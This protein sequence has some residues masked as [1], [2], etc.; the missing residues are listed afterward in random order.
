MKETHAM[1]RLWQSVIMTGIG[2]TLM[3]L[4]LISYFFMLKGFEEHSIRFGV[5]DTLFASSQAEACH[6]SMIKQM[7]L[8]NPYECCQH[9]RTTVCVWLC[10]LDPDSCLAEAGQ[11]L[12]RVEPKV[13][14]P[15][16]DAVDTL[17]EEHLTMQDAFE[18][19]LIWAE[20]EGAFQPKAGQI[21]TPMHIAYMMADLVRPQLH[22]RVID[23]SCGTGNQLVAAW[24]H[25]QRARSSTSWVL[26]SGRVF[27]DPQGLP[28]ST[29][30]ALFG[31]DFNAMM[32]PPCYAHLLLCGVERPQVRCSDALGSVFNQRM[33]QQEWGSIDVVLGN[34]PFGKYLDVP[35]LGATLHQAGTLDAELLFV[36]LTLQLLRE[37]GRA[38][39]LVPE[40]VVRNTSQAAIALRKKLVQE[41]RL[42]A[43]V[44]LP[45]G[46]FLPQANV[47][48]SLLVFHKGE[49][50]GDEVLFYRVAA[51][52]Y[53]FDARRQATPKNNDL[54]DLRACYAVVSGQRPPFPELT[55]ATWWPTYASDKRYASTHHL[56]PSIV[57]EDVNPATGER[58]VP[59]RRIT[60]FVEDSAAVERSWFVSLEEIE[61]TGSYSFCA[62]TYRENMNAQSRSI[63]H[64]RLRKVKEQ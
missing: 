46:I 3:G 51:D 64:Q 14:Y 52:G 26:D 19:V 12:F 37:G 7:A 16:M 22:E 25:M 27:F 61:A 29:E 54:W 32:L 15:L 58:V 33:V 38:A 60:G 57:E 2:D 49:H 35:D 6:W 59:F 23:A 62:D 11:V 50:T 34:S 48:T 45:Q 1:E 31:F 40:G 18:A 39:L 36:E 20:K 42:L 17:C 10:S 47:K 9:L 63:R 24:Q 4:D 8:M 5:Q 43:V 28:R 13:I 44:S 30:P 56:V 53:M 21:M 41:H 55:D